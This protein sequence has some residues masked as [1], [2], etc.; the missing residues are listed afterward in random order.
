LEKKPMSEPTQPVGVEATKPKWPKYVKGESCPKIGV[1]FKHDYQSAGPH[2]VRCTRCGSSR[3][4]YP[5]K[6]LTPAEANVA[7]FQNGNQAAGT[8]IKA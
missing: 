1:G 5:K 2:S 6:P 4:L 8:G 7:L 3:T